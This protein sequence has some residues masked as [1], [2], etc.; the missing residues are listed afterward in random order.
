MISSL[1]PIHELAEQAGIDLPEVLGKVKAQ[2]QEQATAPVAEEAE[3]EP[4]QTD[5]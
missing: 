4:P 5:L 1:P 3:A 2:G